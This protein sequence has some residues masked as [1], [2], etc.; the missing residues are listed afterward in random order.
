MKVASHAFPDRDDVRII[1]NG[2]NPNRLVPRPV[3]SNV[4]HFPSAFFKEVPLSEQRHSQDRPGDDLEQHVA[5]GC[6]DGTCMG[7]AEQ[8]FDAQVL[9]ERRPPH[10]RIAAEVT[11]IAISLAA[12]LVSSTPS[13]AVSQGRSR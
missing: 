8:T 10:V 13:T 12:A 9:R 2:P 7:I 4:C 3:L 5:G 11:L 1:C 6:C